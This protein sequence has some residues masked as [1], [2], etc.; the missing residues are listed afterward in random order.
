MFKKAFIAVLIV[1]MMGS[2]AA[3]REYKGV[4]MPE[5][6]QDGNQLLVLNGV[7]LRNLMII[8]VYVGGLY[9]PGAETNPDIIMNAD[10]PMAIRLQML[11]DSSPKTMNTAL[12]NGM[13]TSSGENYPQIEER[14][15]T[16][17]TFLSDPIEEGNV[18]EFKYLP[19]KGLDVIKNGELKGNIPG[20]DFKQAFF[21]IW[22][23]EKSPADSGLKES[24]LEGKVSPEALAQQQAFANQK[25]EAEKAA[26]LAKANERAK[27]AEMEKAKAEAEARKQADAAAAE[28][29]KQAQA[30]QAAADAEAAKKAEQAKL[31]AAK[32]TKETKKAASTAAPQAPKAPAAAI[33]NAQFENQD[34]YFGVNQTALSGDARN[35]LAAKA[36]WLQQNPDKTVAIEVYS[37]PRGSRE[38]NYELAKQR[39]KSVIDYL[40]NAGINVNRLDTIIYGEDRLVAVGDNEQAWSQ[41][42]RAHFRIK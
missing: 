10:E 34:I 18:F 13:R 28:A 14:I 35:K 39:A 4:D 36:K 12:K 5:T 27:Q 31:M 9:L 25:M 2:F 21:G 11:R 1:L 40:V 41:N 33:D 3:A 20:L 37:D 42:R 8:K 15:N 7:G 6:L 29:E 30:A 17:K 32:A 26:M 24:M 16:F 22:L 19:A 38:Y 23:N